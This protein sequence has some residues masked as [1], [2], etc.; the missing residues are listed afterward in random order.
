M[1]QMQLSVVIPFY[2]E[3]GNVRKV[4]LELESVLNSLSIDYEIIGVDDASTDG[5]FLS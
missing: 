1:N 4:I 5:T 2:N 3:I